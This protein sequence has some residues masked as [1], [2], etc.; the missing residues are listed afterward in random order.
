MNHNQAPAHPAGDE[1]E[2]ANALIRLR[3]VL[4]LVERMTAAPHHV[5]TSTASIDQQAL[6][7]GA[8][9]A[10]GYANAPSIAR[11]RFDALA[12]EAVSFAAAGLGA[13]LQHKQRT[14]DD[15]APAA[16]QLADELRRSIDAMAIIITPASRRR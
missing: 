13:L 2:A 14:G 12:G 15:C 3:G 7:D 11:R 9:L 5:S 4:A 10:L 8:T 16:Q 1:A 6:H